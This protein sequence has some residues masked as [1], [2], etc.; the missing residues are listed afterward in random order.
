MIRILITATLIAALAAC[1]QVKVTDYADSRPLL[2]IEQFFKG[3]LTAHGVVKD[4]GGK[5]IRTFNATIAAHWTDGVGTLVEDFEF[6]DGE[7]QQRIWTLKP[8][9]PGRYTGTAGD[10]IGEGKLQQAGN[11]LFLDYVLRLPYRGSEVDVRVDDRMYLVSPD[12]LINESSMSKFG[13][14]VGNLVLVIVRQQPV[15]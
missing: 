8:D 2:D 15:T 4:R 13:L 6:D 14:R 10:V 9:G 3:N 11:S 12:V 7:T 1:S 5:V